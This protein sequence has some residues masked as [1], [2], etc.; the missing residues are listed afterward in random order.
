MKLKSELKTAKSH[1]IIWFYFRIELNYIIRQRELNKK[2]GFLPPDDT[3]YGEIID[4]PVKPSWTPK[5]TKLTIEATEKEYFDDYLQNIY[6]SMNLW[7][8][9]FNSVHS[10]YTPERLNHFEHN[11]L[12]WREVNPSC[13]KF[14]F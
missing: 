7:R 11:V 8:L 1:C 5:S 6:R 3:I 12:V 4:L 10:K 9:F 13:W 2:S 14:Y